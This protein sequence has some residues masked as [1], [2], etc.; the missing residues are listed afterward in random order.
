MHRLHLLRT[1]VE[2]DALPLPGQGASAAVLPLPS[3][4]R[5]RTFL[6]E[7]IAAHLR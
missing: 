1:P 2:V 3:T 6:R 5:V 7:R 4:E